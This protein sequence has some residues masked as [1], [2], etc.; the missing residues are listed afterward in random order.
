MNKTLAWALIAAPLALASCNKDDDDTAESGTFTVTVE[1][2]FQENDYFTAGATDAIPPGGSTTIS[3][4]AGQGHYLQLATMY[5]ASNDLFF[6]PEDEGLAL[7]DDN[8][9]ALTG[10]ITSSF[11]LWDAGTEVNEE[12]GVG[13]NQPM[14]QSGPNTGMDE[15]GTVWTIDQVG[16]GFT[17]PAADEVFHAHLTHDGGTLF[18]LTIENN[19]DATA[20]PSPLAPGAYVIHS[21]GQYPMFET[22][23][24]AA[25]GLEGLAEDGANTESADWLTMRSGL[26]S[27]FAPGAYSVGT[28]NTV[29]VSGE[30]SSDAL[31]ALAEDGDASGFAN[32]FNTPDG[33]S[34]PGPIFPNGS[35]S[36]SFSATE[37]D[38]LSLATMLVQSN[39][40]FVGLNNIDLFPN[41]QALSGDITGQ[42]R[43]YDSGTEVDMYSGAGGDQPPRQSGPD[44]G[45]E[46]NGIVEMEAS[47]S[48]NVPDMSD[49]IRIS[50][51][52]N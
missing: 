29:F 51:T 33:A 25:N 12:P 43:L 21:A 27:P 41:G 14:N 32:V 38:R 39:D 8:G 49:M 16:D 34:G 40:W 44:T 50:I 52:R 45:E 23:Q 7:Y 28:S 1:N 4:R 47:P 42:A 24:P 5:V 37:G 48:S 20:L 22:G 15:N 46:E 2:V 9:D 36:F 31:E 3:F 30:M 11:I 35:Y 13:P 10:D 6:A 26:V 17:Y 19:S 18:T